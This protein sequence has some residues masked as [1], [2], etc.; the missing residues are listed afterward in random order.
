MTATLQ[1]TLVLLVSLIGPIIIYRNT[2]GSQLHLVVALIFASGACLGGGFALIG[3]SLKPIQL[4]KWAFI[5][6]GVVWAPVFLTTHGI[7]LVALPGIAAY[8]GVVAIAN[9]V[10]KRLI[11][12]NNAAGG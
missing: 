8:A 5:G 3:S 6:G 1:K 12:S 4:C 11:G 2:H 10:T 7:A 9:L